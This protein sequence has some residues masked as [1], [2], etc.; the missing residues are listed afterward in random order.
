ML[1]SE[2]KNYFLFLFLNIHA[3]IDF[4]QRLK[5][6]SL[7]YSV[8]PKPQDLAAQIKSASCN[9]CIKIQEIKSALAICDLAKKNS[10]AVT[11]YEY[12]KE[13]NYYEQFFTSQC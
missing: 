2:N 1:S 5:S 12:K 4:D 7:E 11:I 3:L 9:F 13:K 8:I 10:I 6:T